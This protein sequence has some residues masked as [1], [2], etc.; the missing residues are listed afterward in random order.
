MSCIGVP[1]TRMHLHHIHCLLLGGACH[2]DTA[3]RHHHQGR[4]ALKGNSLHRNWMYGS[5]KCP[6]GDQR[7]RFLKTLLGRKRR[8]RPKILFKTH[9]GSLAWN[10]PHISYSRTQCTSWKRLQRP[11]GVRPSRNH[12]HLPRLERLGIDENSH[13]TS[14][15]GSGCACVPPKQPFRAQQYDPM[16]N[17]DHCIS[18]S[19][20]PAC[21][22]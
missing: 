8:N 14:L 13:H 3:S 21:G 7:M 12:S 4:T 2:R 16:G 19:F 10:S 18:S 22:A 11:L 1:S 20:C 15:V 6:V 5:D 17:L 9:L